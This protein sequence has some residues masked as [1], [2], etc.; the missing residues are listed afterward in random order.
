GGWF[1]LPA[2]FEGP[3]YFANFLGPIFG[4]EQHAELA[5]AIPAHTLELILAGV[6]VT[7]ALIGL[8]VASWLYR[9]KPGKADAI[10]GS[11]QPVYKTLLNK[12]Y[13]DELYAAVIVKP[14]LW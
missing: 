3:D 7:S 12:Y 5:G 1:A 6:A 13:V 10:P 14:L 8:G 4:G 11:M 9:K 2:F